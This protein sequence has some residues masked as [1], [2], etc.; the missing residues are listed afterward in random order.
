MV[1]NKKLRILMIEDE[2]HDAAL[3]EH[4]LKDG[5]FN[6]SLKRVDTE[7]DSAPRMSEEFKPRWRGLQRLGPV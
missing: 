7:Q 5:G 6:F 1:T 2:A 3:V 4:S